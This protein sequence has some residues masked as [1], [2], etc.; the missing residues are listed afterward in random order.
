MTVIVFLI[1]LAA[2]LC[3]NIINTLYYTHMFQLNGYKPKVQRAWLAKRLP[4]VLGRCLLV[5]FGLLFLPFFSVGGKIVSILCFLLSAYLCRPRKAKKPLVYTARVKR[6]LLTDGIVWVLICVLL[7][8][9]RTIPVLSVVLLATA[10]FFAPWILLLANLINRPVETGINNHY[11]NDAKR[12]IRQSPS[13]Q[14]IGITG[15]YGKTSVKYFLQTLLSTVYDSLM[16]PESYN[17]TLGVVRTVREQLHPTHEYFV[18]EMGARNVG[19]I[20]EICDIVLPSYGIL[21]AIG[22]QHLESFRSIE[23]IVKTKFELVDA[24][25]DSGTAF[26]NYDNEWIRNRPVSCKTISYG[27]EYQNADYFGTDIVLSSKGTSFSVVY[28]GEKIPFST[29]LI[30]A[31]NVQNLVGAI[32]AAHTLGVPVKE[33]QM[34]VRQI[35]SVP[36]RLQLLPRG[37]VNIIDDAYNSNPSGAKA[38][39]DTLSCFDGVKIVV[40]PGMVELGEKEAE[41]NFTFGRQMAKVCDYAVLIG[42]ERVFPIRDGLLEEGFPKEKIFLYRQ[43]TEGIQRAYALPSGQKEKFILLENDLPDNY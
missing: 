27:I 4:P 9:T 38:A 26:L 21:T 23:N 8:L 10:S 14:V 22:P 15:S 3:Y 20:R 6:L 40:T 24:L 43:F 17:T 33:L 5:L 31:H 2:F 36:H 11:I 34:G 1:L 18:C 30:G 35:Q 13:L 7:F 28:K 19:D 39:L 16:T 37:N 25:G 32:A 29:S 42:G 41:C 12:I